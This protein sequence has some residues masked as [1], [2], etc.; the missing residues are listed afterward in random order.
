MYHEQRLLEEKS[1]ESPLIKVIRE[2]IDERRAVKRA[3]REAQSNQNPA[4][5]NEKDA[6][7]EVI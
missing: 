6:E 3:Q 2:A 5:A 1:E 7:P 4:I